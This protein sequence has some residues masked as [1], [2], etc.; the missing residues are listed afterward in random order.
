MDDGLLSVDEQGRIRAALDDDETEMIKSHRATKRKHGHV[1]EAEIDR[2]NRE[3]A[4]E[5]Q[6]N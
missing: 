6:K 4:K 2:I 3:L 1:D 5:E